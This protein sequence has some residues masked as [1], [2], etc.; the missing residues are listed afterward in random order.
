[1]IENILAKLVTKHGSKNICFRTVV[2]V[3]T[4]LRLTKVSYWTHFDISI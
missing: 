1:M 3:Y 2:N 4:D